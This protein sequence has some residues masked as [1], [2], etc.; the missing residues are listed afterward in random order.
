MPIQRFSSALDSLYLKKRSAE[1]ARLFSKPRRWLVNNSSLGLNIYGEPGV[2]IT[3]TNGVTS[4]PATRNLTSAG[5]DFTASGVQ[6]GDVVEIETP[7]PNS[8]DDGKYIVHSI[9]GPT[10]LK[11]TENWP[12]GSL[13]SLIYKVHF[14]D[15]RY[16]E[17]VQ[18]VPFEIHL[19]PTEKLL[20]KWG[21]SD[22]RDAMIVVSTQ[23]CEELGLDP[24]IGDRFVYEQDGTLAH[25]EVVNLFKADQLNDSGLHVN[26][27]GFAMKTQDRLP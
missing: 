1:K 20:T 16:T 26:Y 18:L 4:L 27:V 12:A 14:H 15:E 25:Y 23:I 21:I 3:G 2:A 9:V 7:P 11:V 17:F 22:N 6:A 5:S 8:A 13:T 19:K 10:V 24:K